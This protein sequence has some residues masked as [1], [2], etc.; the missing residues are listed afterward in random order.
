MIKFVL[1]PDKFILKIMNKKLIMRIFLFF[2]LLIINVFSAFKG[3]SQTC[4]DNIKKGLE[5]T[6]ITTFDKVT[7]GAVGEFVVRYPL[8]GTTY[9]LTDQAGATYTRTY[10]GTPVAITLRIPIGAVNTTRRFSL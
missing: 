4:E 7:Q 3:Y 10:T 9:T 2:I 6:R 8:A 5:Q 1:L